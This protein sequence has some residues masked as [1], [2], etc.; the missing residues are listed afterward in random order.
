MIRTTGRNGG[1]NR[2]SS[3]DRGKNRRDR[4]VICGDGDTRR[5]RLGENSRSG[6]DLSL[7]AI[8]AAE[9]TDQGRPSREDSDEDCLCDLGRTSGL[10]MAIE[11]TVSY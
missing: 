1:T 6:Q 4:L 11:D 10:D 3:G 2:E 8:R 5:T 9:W 7:S